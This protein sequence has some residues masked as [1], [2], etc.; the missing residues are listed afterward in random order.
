MPSSSLESSSNLE[1]RRQ[2]RVVSLQSIPAAISSNL[3]ERG[4]KFFFNRFATA[5]SA[6]QGSPYDIKSLS[7]LNAISLEVPLREAVVSV[8]LAALSNI[9][10]DRSLLLASR[11]KHMGTINSVRLAVENPE[12]ASPDQTFKLIVMLSLYEV[13]PNKGPPACPS[14]MRLIEILDRW[15]AAQQVKS[16]HGQYILTVWQP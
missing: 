6:F 13:S 10:K 1:L 9:T 3:E 8:G 7:F 16:T 12:Q 2:P 11:E 4:L 14:F 15:S 5:V